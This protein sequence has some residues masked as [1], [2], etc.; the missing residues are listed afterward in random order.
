MVRSCNI[1]LEATV[2]STRLSS[3]GQAVIPQEVRDALGLEVGTLF[4][5]VVQ[6]DKVILEPLLP[7]YLGFE[8]R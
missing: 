7:F 5:V 4:Q 1:L 3:K 6:E 2:L 8:V